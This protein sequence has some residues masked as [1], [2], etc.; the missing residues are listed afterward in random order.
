MRRFTIDSPCRERQFCLPTMPKT[1]VPAK[2]SM[3]SMIEDIL[4]RAGGLAEG[5]PVSS[6]T[7][8]DLGTACNSQCALAATSVSEAP[9]SRQG[10]LRYARRQPFWEQRSIFSD[11]SECGGKRLRQEPHSPFE[12]TDPAFLVDLAPRRDVQQARSNLQGT[13]PDRERSIPMP[14]QPYCPS[15]PSRQRGLQDR[16]LPAIWDCLVALMNVTQSDRLMS[17]GPPSHTRHSLA[18]EQ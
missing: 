13:L 11:R 2:S 1:Q 10:N 17:K 9:P 14:H 5:T 15:E 3:A 6:R 16:P 18:R 8:L 4:T 7:L 12:V